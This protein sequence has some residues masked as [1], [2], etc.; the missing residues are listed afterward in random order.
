MHPEHTIQLLVDEDDNRAYMYVNLAD[1]PWY[2]RV[3][4]AVKYIFGKHDLAYEETIIDYSNSRRMVNALN[5][6]KRDYKRKV[7]F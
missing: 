6:L 1:L 2:R 5:K 3:W 4:V 7:Q